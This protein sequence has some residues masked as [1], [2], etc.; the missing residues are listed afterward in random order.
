MPQPALRDLTFSLFVPCIARP[1]L[2][3]LTMTKVSNRRCLAD[4][5]SKSSPTMGN[6]VSE[7]IRAAIAPAS[8]TLAPCPIKP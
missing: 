3:S 5:V 1:L 4:Q 7:R 6:A 8:A 2:H